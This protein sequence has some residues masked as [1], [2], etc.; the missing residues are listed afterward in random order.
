[1]KKSS[2]NKDLRYTKDLRIT[3]VTKTLIPGGVGICI[4]D[5]HKMYF[6]CFISTLKDTTTSLKCFKTV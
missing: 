3:W 2:M 6:I 1:M 5:F 4:L